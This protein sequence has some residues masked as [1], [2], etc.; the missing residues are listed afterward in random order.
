[1]TYRLS[2]SKY[3][4]AFQCHKRLW[5]EFHDPEKATPV[6]EVQQAIFNQGHYVG[7]L[8]REQ[9]PDG[10]L[11][12]SHYL[13]ISNG[14]E[15]TND[16]LA[17]NPPSIFE[18]FFQYNDVL[19]RPD[20]MVNN[21]DGTWDF[22]E[23]KSS[24]KVKPENIRDVAIQTYVLMGCK[25]K[26]RKSFL[27]HINRSCMYPDLNN[28]FHLEELTDSIKPFIKE[29]ESSLKNLR[30]I[31]SV[32]QPPDIPIGRHC[33]K[34]YN[35]AFKTYCWVDVPEYSVFTIPR[36]NQEKKDNY[37]KNGV[38]ELIDFKDFGKLNETQ[39]NY[40]KSYKTKSP[41]IDKDAIQNELENLVFPLYFLDFETYAPAVPQFEGMHPYEQF[42]FQYSLHILQ[43][44]GSLI[45][46]EY[47]HD[48]KTDPRQQIA[49]QLVNDLGELGTIIS[50]NAS[51]EKGIISNLSKFIPNYSNQL[52]LLTNRFW[53]QLL[54]F[55]KYYFDYRFRGSNSIKSV[56]PVL[57]PNL[58]YKNLEVQEGKQ[59]QIVWDKMTQLPVGKGKAKLKSQLLEYCR[60]DTLA[61]VEIHNKLNKI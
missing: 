43:K 41:I 28:L 32:N 21:N 51:F 34:P 35:C 22:I 36:L 38:S 49:K 23:V 10:I 52:E 25:V 39:K 46:K 16:E 20:I 6:S 27:M 8:A 5:L 48:N 4:S 11:I 53:D 61:M 30:N 33:D 42:P 13:D 19:V 14:I 59:A 40:L 55:R 45:Q 31:L 9:Y 3:L 12:D 58:D 1:M 47:I 2:K 26:I 54:I 7:E 44:D 60:M 50:Y 15:T 18:G 29:M 56:L 24:T 17:K 37:Y 57:V